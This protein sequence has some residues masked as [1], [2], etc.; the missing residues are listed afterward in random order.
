M[1]LRFFVIPRKCGSSVSIV[2]ALQIE[3]WQW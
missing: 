1:L 2:T 3:H